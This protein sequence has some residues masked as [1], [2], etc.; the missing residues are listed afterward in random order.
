MD[1]INAK[2]GIIIQA[3]MGSTRLAGKIMLRLGS[4]PLLEHILHRLSL[5]R[6]RARTVIATT[7]KPQDD[8]VEAFCKE[9]GIEFFR[10]S[11]SNVLKRYYLCAKAYG[12]DTIVRLT[13]DNPF[14][15]VEEL[16]R[17]IEMHTDSKSDFS[18]SFRSLPVGVGAEIFK[19][20]ALERSFSEAKSPH[21]LEHVDEYLLENPWLFKTT[22]LTVTGPKNR[23]KVRLTV[24]T[25]EDYR[26]ACF[27]VEHAKTDP[28]TTEEA[29]RLCSQFA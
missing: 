24:D 2:L 16:D 22:E 26:R 21:H 10:G 4:K 9:K 15:D 29:I 1:R 8:I 18:H 14:V 17:L 23:P 12:F 3:R 19:F 28:V 7:F 25:E 20:S 6:H 13:G 5:L 11:E 27:I